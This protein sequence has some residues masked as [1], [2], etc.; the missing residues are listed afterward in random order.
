MSRRRTLTRTCSHTGCTERSFVEYTA[1]RDLENVSPTWKCHRHNKPNEI[2]SADNP[3]TTA[4][5]TLH[6]SYIDGYRHEDPP[7]LVGYF[8]GPE[9]AEKGHS[10]IESGPGFRAIAKDFP[11]GTRLIVTARIELPDTDDTRT[12]NQGRTEALKA[13]WSRYR[14]RVL[15]EVWEAMRDAEHGPLIDAMGVIN[16]MLEEQ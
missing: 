9:D 12:A 5:L 8:W 6:P 11:P 3:E 2:L 1:R 13:D 16:K 4:V 14:G 15:A 7:R 10:G